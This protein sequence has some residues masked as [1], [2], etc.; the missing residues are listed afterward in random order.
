MS[1]K[2]QT[3]LAEIAKAKGNSPI[4]EPE[5]IVRFARDPSTALHGEFEWDDTK[6]GHQHRLWQARQLLRVYIKMIDAGDGEVPVRMFYNIV[7][8]G[9]RRGYMPTENVLSDESR[10]A[11]LIRGQLTRLWNIYNSYPLPELKPVGTA[12]ERVQRKFIV[13]D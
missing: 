1:D 4:I 2:K 5:A 7:E 3:I 11:E 6:A 10:R 8:E 13:A 12:I 9:D